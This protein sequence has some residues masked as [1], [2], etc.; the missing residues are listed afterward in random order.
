MAVLIITA[1]LPARAQDEFYDEF[2]DDPEIQEMVFKFE[3]SDDLNGY[4][5]SPNKYGG[6]NWD[7]EM[8]LFVPSIRLQ[9]GKPVVGLSGFESLK[10]L[11]QIIFP[12]DCHVKYICDKCFQY[13]TSLVSTEPLTLP[14]TIETIGDYAFYGCSR[15]IEINLPGTLTYIG[16]SAFEECTSLVSITL[17]K[18]LKVIREFAFRNCANFDFLGNFIGGG[19]ESVTFEDGVDFYTNNGVYCFYGYVFWGC[20]N[21]SSVKL[22]NGTPGRFVIPM[23]TFGYCS[24]LRSIEFPPNTGKIEQ[25]AFYRS[26]L[27]TLDL[28]NITWKE[29]FYLDGYYTFA[30]CENLTTVKAKGK[31][32]F[33]GLYT[34]QDCTALKTVTFTGEGDDYTVM[35]PDIFKRCS[36]LE[37]V[38]FYHLKGNG[39]DNDMD[40]VFTDCKKLV[41][42]TST[43]T[44]EISKIGYSCF[45]GCESLRELTLPK[46][47]FA[48]NETAFRG[49]TALKSFDFANVTSIGKGSFSG[50]TGL[51]STPNISHL[52]SITESAFQGCSSLPSLELA[53]LTSIGTKAFAGCTALTS[54]TFTNNPPTTT[55]EDAFDEWHFSNT[56]I[57]VLDEKYSAFADDAVWQKFLKL[58]HPALFAYTPVEGGYSIAKGQ[59]ALAEDFAGML[60]IPTEYETGKVVAIA[61]GA[62]EGLAGIT[63]VTLHK[64]LTTVGAN[65]FAGCTGI[66]GV[67]SERAEPLT[68]DASAFAQQA[69][70]G[71]L[72][73][74]FGSLDAYSN[75]A[76]WSAFSKIEQGLGERTLAK[77]T[78]S[79]ESCEFKDSFDLTLTNPNE[80]GTIYYY[81]IP[82]G[83][84]STGVREVLAYEGPIAVPATNYTVVAYISN[85]TACS[86]PITLV[87]T[88]LP[89]QID[90]ITS[91]SEGSEVV[92]FTIDPEQSLDNV[93]IDN[94]YYSINDEASG[95]NST[96]GLV[97]NATTS[98]DVVHQF[99]S[100]VKNGIDPATY[101]NGI[102]VKVQGVGSITFSDYTNSGDAR[103]TLVLGDGSPVYVDE[104]TGGKYEFSLPAAKYL[105]IFASQAAPSAAP[106]LKA[107]AP[108]ENS[109]T[110]TSMTLNVSDLYISTEEGLDKI[111]AANPGE[112]YRLSRSL[113]GHYYDGTYLYASTIGGSGSSKNTYNLGK[114]GNEGSDDWHHANQDDW[115]AISGLTEENAEEYLGQIYTVNLVVEVISNDKYPVI[116][117]PVKPD[118]VDPGTFEHHSFRVENFNYKADNLAVSNIWLIAPQPAEYCTLR[119]FV[120]ME[121]IHTEDGYLELMSEEYTKIAADETPIPPLSVKVYYSNAAVSDALDVTAWYDFTGIV[122]R[123]GEDLVFTAITA[124]YKLPSAIEDVEATSGARIS[125]ANGSINVVCDTPTTITVYSVT[126]QLVATVEATTATIPVAPGLYL[127]KAGSQTTKLSVR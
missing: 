56:L 40:S 115:V 64:D 123:E 23:G 55:I 88:L 116:S 94:I 59:F 33:D 126:G 83:D 29:P 24:N 95:M 2:Y 25:L 68:A 14:E 54:I 69:Y 9:D 17:P 51:E 39:Q 78:S 108:G 71:T 87:F 31:V 41:R 20:A 1:A 70:S 105:Y 75:C 67:I 110:L 112:S 89:C 80:V 3:F 125:A 104:L 106:Q 13:C 124:E 85:G 63:G 93:V 98:I 36:N 92:D 62:F 84:T 50:C 76:P 120:R 127:V 16:V 102:A 114:L 111:L 65:A 15:I 60:E 72:T 47:A 18:S 82:K 10:Y 12:K 45:D 58:K 48:I 6:P 66:T 86:E 34:F 44:P 117:F 43:L 103:L 79:H 19:L 8:Q 38:D 32:R 49:C 96:N 21:L 100:D 30:A 109:V 73:V 61:D 27:D 52:T 5:I 53:D 101:F 121:N 4:I 7:Q 99:N 57:D 91:V 74:P 46:Q 113:N 97:L 118:F 37:S 122:S 28:T 35:N 119:G 107:P 81:V 22:P 11:D 90:K 42:V 77:P 26:G